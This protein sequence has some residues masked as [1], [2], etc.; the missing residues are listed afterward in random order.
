MSILQEIRSESMHTFASLLTTWRANM[1]FSLVVD[2]ERMESYVSKYI[3]KNEPFGLQG[4]KLQ[5]KGRTKA[6]E[7][8]T[9]R[10]LA[11]NNDLRVTEY[12]RR[13]WK[14][15]RVV[16]GDVANWEHGRRWLHCVRIG[17]AYFWAKLKWLGCNVPEGPGCEW[18]GKVEVEDD[19]RHMILECS[20][21]QQPR[22]ECLSRWIGDGSTRVFRRRNR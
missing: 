8:L 5:L 22:E 4:W 16:G 13:F 1:D 18:C 12:V 10:T 15:E 7:T 3:T 2:R 9:K 17:A 20:A 14:K 11:L 6:M 21:W 19:A